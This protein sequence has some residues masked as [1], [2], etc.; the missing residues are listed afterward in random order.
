M[1][2]I[3]GII[4][5]IAAGDRIARVIGIT[6]GFAVTLVVVLGGALARIFGR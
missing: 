1:L 4:L 3:L 5:A 6:I 2:W